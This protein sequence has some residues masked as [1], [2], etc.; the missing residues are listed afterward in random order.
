VLTNPTRGATSVTVQLVGDYPAGTAVTAGPVATTGA[1]PFLASFSMTSS[2]PIVR[3]PGV[4]YQ[5]GLRVV[6]DYGG[7]LIEIGYQPI[8]LRVRALGAAN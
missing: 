1:A 5:F 6:A 8:T 2:L 4:F 7:G 3:P